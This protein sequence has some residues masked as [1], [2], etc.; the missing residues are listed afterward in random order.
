[1]DGSVD[2]QNFVVLPGHQFLDLLLLNLVEWFSNLLEVK[3]M[4]VVNEELGDLGL[5]MAGFDP[6]MLPNEVTL[7]TSDGLVAE[8]C[9]LVE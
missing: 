1:M 6:F 7:A 8:E 5:A 2:R 9:L 4:D 3:A